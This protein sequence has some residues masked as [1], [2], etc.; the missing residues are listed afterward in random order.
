MSGATMTAIQTA[1]T[2]GVADY[3]PKSY[4]NRGPFRIY[5]PMNP[6]A[7]AFDYIGVS[8]V[9]IDT[10]P[11]Q[12]LA[13]GYA[14]SGQVSA[15]TELSSIYQTLWNPINDT[16]NAENHATH[17]ASMSGWY[18]PDSIILSSQ[19]L[20]GGESLVGGYTT[21]ALLPDFNPAQ[22]LLDESFANTFS[23]AKHCNTSY[24]GRK[25]LVNIYKAVTTEFGEGY[26]G[27]V[28]GYGV[29]FK[30]TNIFDFERDI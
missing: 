12:H 15:S 7:R 27:S 6:E 10:R 24:S 1:R 3:G 14:L 9:G 13:Q 20:S 17:L 29:G 30:S 5:F 11:Y 21:K 23:N 2:G 22:V 8:A 18:Y 4:E 26:V 28:S 19:E 16:L 25:R